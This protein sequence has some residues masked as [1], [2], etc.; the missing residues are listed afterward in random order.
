AEAHVDDVH[1]VVGIA[2]GREA[3]HVVDTADDVRPVPL[4]RVAQ[5]LDRDE[6]GGR[7][8]AD[9]PD[10]VAR[11]G[12]DDPGD[13]GPVTVAVLGRTGV[14]AVAT[15]R[16]VDIRDEVRMREVD[17]GIEDGDARSGAREPLVVGIRSGR[18]RGPDTGDAGRDR[19]RGDVDGAVRNDV[20]DAGPLLE[21]PGLLGG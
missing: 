13:V 5:D 12:R 8:N 10:V 9:D 4:A 21:G 11:L 15:E 14:V 18:V 20:A 3:G 19:L 1:V 17:P 6:A 2:V 16:A 7:G